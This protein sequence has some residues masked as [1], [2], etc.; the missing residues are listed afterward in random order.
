M[1]KQKDSSS[2]HIIP[3]SLGGINGLEIPVDAKF[4][5]SEASKI[6]AS[7][8]EDFL[9]KMKRNEFD[10]RGHSGKRPIYIAKH[11]KEIS[12]GKPIQVGLDKNGLSIWDSVARKKIHGQVEFTSSFSI[13]LDNDFKFIAKAALSGGYFVFGDIFRGFVDHSELRLIMNNT[14]AEL[15]GRK[16]KIRTLADDRFFETSD[17]QIQTFRW[18]CESTQNASIIGFVP[19]SNSLAIFVGILGTYLGMLNV[20]ANTSSFPRTGD[21]EFGHV[22]CPQSGILKRLSFKRTLEILTSRK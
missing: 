6:D 4:N 2:E 12:T 5:S 3:L 8:A 7:L 9:I 18:L 1:I 11:S 20:P 16:H 15:R 14:S 19:S 13:E 10:V 21:F 22:L 17:E